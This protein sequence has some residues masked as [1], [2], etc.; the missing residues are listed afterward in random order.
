M[1]K[2]DLVI[3]GNVVVRGDTLSDGGGYI[4]SLG[5]DEGLYD[6]KGAIVIDGNL[7]V[8][9]INMCGRII[10]VR[11]TIVVIGKEAGDGK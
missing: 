1:K 8:D 11:G 7:D 2:I 5:N 10:L 9:N 3:N 6:T 4:L